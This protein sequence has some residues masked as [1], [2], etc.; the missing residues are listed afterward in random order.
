M[1]RWVVSQKCKNVPKKEKRMTCLTLNALTSTLGTSA[2]KCA[3]HW[4]NTDKPWTRAPS[5]T[6]ENIQ[7]SMFNNRRWNHIVCQWSTIGKTK[8]RNKR[9]DSSHYFTHK[10][11]QTLTFLR[12]RKLKFD[13][14]FKARNWKLTPCLSQET[15]SWQTLKDVLCTAKDTKKCGFETLKGYSSCVYTISKELKETHHH[16]HHHH[17]HHHH[18]HHHLQL[19]EEQSTVR[20]VQLAR[21]WEVWTM[22]SIIIFL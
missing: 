15:S 5:W 14:V 6:E 7:K 1:G 16:H 13:T 9:R 22:S 3:H 8:K 11:S 21:S 17:R 12:E 2:E 18:Y 19:A 4:L 20:H 10:G